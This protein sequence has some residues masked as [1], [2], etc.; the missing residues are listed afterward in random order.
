MRASKL[1]GRWLLQPGPRVVWLPGSR[2][3]IKTSLGGIVRVTRMGSH[4][5]TEDLSALVLGHMVE[6]ILDCKCWEF[7]ISFVE[8]GLLTGRLADADPPSQAV[9]INLHA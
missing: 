3:S 1:A 5:K 2:V 6:E 8:H 7:G 9:R 4:V